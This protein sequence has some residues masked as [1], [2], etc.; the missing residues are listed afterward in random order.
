MQAVAGGEN[1]TV[2]APRED[3][4]AGRADY[5]ASIGPR[6]IQFYS[7][8]FHTPYMLPKMDLVNEPSKGG[9]ME[10]WVGRRFDWICTPAMLTGPYPV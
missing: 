7:D 10:N 3:V 5:A 6:I 4:M 8:H 9:A 1:V 2:W